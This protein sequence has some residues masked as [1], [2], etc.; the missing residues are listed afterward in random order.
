M[1]SRLHL[2]ALAV[3]LVAALQAPRAES[4][5]SALQVRV[6]VVRSCSVDTRGASDQGTIALTCGRGM[7]AGVVSTGVGPNTRVIPVPARQTTFVPARPAAAAP[8]G[9][10][11]STRLSTRQIVTVNF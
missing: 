5:S 2:L 10:G 6:N 8:G 3:L 4:R 1:Y 9:S 7:T 11:P